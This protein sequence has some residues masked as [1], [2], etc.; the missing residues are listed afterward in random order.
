NKGFSYEGKAFMK[1]SN[2]L[3]KKV[4][5]PSKITKKRKPL[6]LFVSES[7]LKKAF[8]IRESLY[9]VLNF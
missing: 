4:Y 9:D 5:S 1:T 6:P 2:Y 7:K 8:P 3:L